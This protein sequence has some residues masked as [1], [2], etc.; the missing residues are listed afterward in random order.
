MWN[1]LKFTWRVQRETRKNRKPIVLFFGNGYDSQLLLMALHKL[2]KKFTIV[3]IVHGKFTKKTRNVL[4]KFA[5]NPKI[6]LRPREEEKEFKNFYNG[7]GF[8]FEDMDFGFSP[9]DYLIVAGFKANTEPSLIRAFYNDA[10]CDL[11]VPL[12]R[13]TDDWIER[14]YQEMKDSEKLGQ[15]MYDNLQSDSHHNITIN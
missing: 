3:Y 10:F 5:Q 7:D 14:L 1:F 8:C 6:I 13:Y 4:Q 9:K 2:K 12:L 11:Y 15:F